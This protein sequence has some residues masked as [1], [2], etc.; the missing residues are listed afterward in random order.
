MARHMHI[1]RARLTRSVTGAF[2]ALVFCAAA[3]FLIAQ[4]LA[5]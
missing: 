4:H 2:T 5:R 3:A 1:N